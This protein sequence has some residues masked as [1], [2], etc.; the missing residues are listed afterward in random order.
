M[1][2]GKT[3]LFRELVPK[4]TTRIIAGT[5][6]SSKAE[7]A[8]KTRLRSVGTGRTGQSCSCPHALVSPMDFLHTQE[9]PNPHSSPC[10]GRL[11]LLPRSVI[12]TARRQERSTR[13]AFLP[14]VATHGVISQ[15]N[16]KLFLQRWKPPPRAKRLP[17][18]SSQSTLRWQAGFVSRPWLQ[19]TLS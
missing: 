6:N 7:L 11:A 14:W 8:G 17:V 9:P 3:A 18:K 19:Q 15:P 2:P 12:S 13:S 1:Y 5:A 16:G 10:Q 4:L